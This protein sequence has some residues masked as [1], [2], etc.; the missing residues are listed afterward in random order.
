MRTEHIKDGWWELPGK[1]VAELDWPGTKNGSNHRVWLPAAA[2]AIIEELEATGVVF[3]GPR[4]RAIGMLDGPMREI[5][6]AL[7]VEPATPHDLRRYA[8]H[9]RCPSAL[10]RP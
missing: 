9:D 4:G 2:K 8:R 5:S 7:K 10:L 6:K 1:P 3:A